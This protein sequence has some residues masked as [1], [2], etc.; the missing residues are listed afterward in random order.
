MSELSAEQFVLIVSIIIILLMVMK[1]FNLFFYRKNRDGDGG[2]LVNVE[3]ASV[4]GYVPFEKHDDAI[5]LF[6]LGASQSGQGF[7]PFEIL[8]AVAIQDEEEEEEEEEGEEGGEE[9]RC[10]VEFILD[11]LKVCIKTKTSTA[12]KKR[13]SFSKDLEEV[14]LFD[15]HF[16]EMN[17]DCDE[18]VVPM[19]LDGDDGFYYVDAFD[20][21][22]VVV[23]MDLDGDDGFY[24]VQTVSMDCD[25]DDY[26]L[27]MDLDGDDGF[28]YVDA[29]DCDDVVVPMDLDGDDG[30][31]QV[32]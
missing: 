19:D 29:F 8:V 21:D 25:D 16:I 9:E 20:C 28:Y 5:S 31:Y 17:M 15:S 7:V 24:Q 32:Q 3:D 18:V 13:V 2:L 6:C 27:P 23:P 30:F 12:K 22:D 26:V 4:D 1:T 14:R 10:N 11:E